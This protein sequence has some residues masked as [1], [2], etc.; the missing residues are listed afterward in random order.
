MGIAASN[1]YDPLVASFAS[2]NISSLSSTPLSLT[3]SSGVSGFSIL[4]KMSTSN[5]IKTEHPPLGKGVPPSSSGNSSTSCKS[6]RRSRSESDF[7]TGIQPK[8]Q[9]KQDD[10]RSSKR[11]KARERQNQEK[12]THS[13]EEEKDKDADVDADADADSITSASADEDEDEDADADANAPLPP[14]LSTQ[15]VEASAVT[16]K[17]S[18]LFRACSAGD[19]ARLEAI[20]EDRGL[21][22]MKTQRDTDGWAASHWAAQHVHPRVLAWL[23]SKDVSFLTVCSTVRSLITSLMRSQ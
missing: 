12:A 10:E 5:L 20:L 6:R 15:S 9:E 22:W 4:K 3:H 18:D 23:Y 1:S 11:V 17:A 16:W 8:N 14:S 13:S 19:I 7:L 21:E 2:H